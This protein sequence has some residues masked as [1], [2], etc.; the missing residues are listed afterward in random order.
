MDD[1]MEEKMGGAP[2]EVLTQLSF[3]GEGLY[4]RL[5]AL[6]EAE[7]VA[8]QKAKAEET[9]MCCETKSDRGV[10]SEDDSWQSL[11]AFPQFMMLFACRQVWDN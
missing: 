5:V 11:L 10:G 2:Q 3:R 4:C 6:G 7:D 1:F 8:C 9:L